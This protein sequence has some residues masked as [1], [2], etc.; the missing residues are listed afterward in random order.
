MGEFQAKKH[1]AR[2]PRWPS[3]RAS[4]YAEGF[5]PKT[6]GSLPVTGRTRV[7]KRAPVPRSGFGEEG[8]LDAASGSGGVCSPTPH[9]FWRIVFSMQRREMARCARDG[10]LARAHRQCVPGRERVHVVSPVRDFPIFNLDDRAKSICCIAR[11]SRAP[12]LGLHIR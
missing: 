11:L 5:E 10:L 7:A 2:C 12:S 1:L 9:G 4:R 6:G 8:G 3:V